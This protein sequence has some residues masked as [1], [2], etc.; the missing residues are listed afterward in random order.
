V[1]GG[2]LTIVIS[3]LSRTDLV[4]RAVHAALQEWRGHLDAHSLKNVSILVIFNERSGQ[5]MRVIVRPESTHE[6]DGRGSG[7][8]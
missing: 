1:A 4:M 6:L 8:S 3:G 5:P 7:I 2:E